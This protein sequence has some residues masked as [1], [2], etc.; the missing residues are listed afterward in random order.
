MRSA[1]AI[2]GISLQKQGKNGGFILHFV[3]ALEVS[4]IQ[5]M[6]F[7]DRRD[8]PLRQPVLPLQVSHEA[9]FLA[10]KLWKTNL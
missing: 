8:R 10:V 2:P 5:I 7:K 9:G 3:G 4:D 6:L 1:F